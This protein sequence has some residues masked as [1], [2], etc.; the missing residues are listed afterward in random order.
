MIADNGFFLTRKYKYGIVPKQA[1]YVNGCAQDN[2]QTVITAIPKFQIQS[3]AN[4]IYFKKIDLLFK[5]SL[6]KSPGPIKVTTI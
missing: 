6:N 5:S 1:T 2:I 3:K 4:K